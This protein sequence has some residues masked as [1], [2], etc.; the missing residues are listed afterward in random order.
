PHQSLPSLIQKVKYT[1]ALSWR[2]DP[3][4]QTK[5][6]SAIKN[7]TTLSTAFGK[8]RDQCGIDWGEQT[9]ASFHEIRSLSERL[10]REQGINTQKLL[11]H[12]SQKMT[13]KYNN[14]RG[15]EFLK[16]DYD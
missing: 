3:T 6:G 7:A 15:K 2:H 14:N 12:A 5:A 4:S 13:D 10:Y 16:L 1:A 8:L 9:P 11:G